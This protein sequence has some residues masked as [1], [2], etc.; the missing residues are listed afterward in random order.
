MIRKELILVVQ[1]AAQVY[2]EYTKNYKH[3]TMEMH[4]LTK[5][6]QHFLMDLLPLPNP[7]QKL[8]K[9]SEMKQIAN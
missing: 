4:S 9:S 7:F 2:R 6:Q 8:N 3:V 5:D 1:K